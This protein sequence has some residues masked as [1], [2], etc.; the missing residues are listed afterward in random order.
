MDTVTHIIG[1]YGKVSCQLTKI[2]D[3]RYRFSSE[4][5]FFRFGGFPENS[6]RVGC[7]FVDPAGGPFISVDDFLSD[8]HPNLPKRKIVEIRNTMDGGTTL[9]LE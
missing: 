9:I 4:D 7:S 2:D 8:F 5:G 6:D 1:R 3:N